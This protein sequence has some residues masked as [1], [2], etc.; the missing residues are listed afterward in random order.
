MVVDNILT[1]KKNQTCKILKTL[2]V[3]KNKATMRL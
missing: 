3:I 1:K 2:Q